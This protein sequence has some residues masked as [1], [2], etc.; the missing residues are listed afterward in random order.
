MPLTATVPTFPGMTPGGAFSVVGA[1]PLG[2]D[3]L[4]A[5]AR[6]SSP[7]ER[8]AVN[9]A[10]GELGRI[11]DP[12]GSTAIA[13]GSGIG[14]LIGHEWNRFTE[15]L[16]GL[17]PGGRERGRQQQLENLTKNRGDNWISIPGWDDLI[18]LA[19][20]GP[21][22]TSE[23]KQQLRDRFQQIENSAQPD[24]SQSF[25]QI[26]TALDN[27]QD[28]T[29]ALAVAG[30]M[31]L[32][33]IGKFVGG[34]LTPILGPI[35]LAGDILKL[36][37][38][39]GLIA[40]PLYGLICIGPR[41]LLSGAVPA[42]VFGRVGKNMAETAGALNPLGR[43]ARLARQLKLGRKLPGFSELIEIAQ[44]TDSLFGVGI[45]F[46]GLV[47]ALMEGAFGLNRPQDAGGVTVN[48]TPVV[49]SFNNLMQG[50]IGGLDVGSTWIGQTAGS[51]LRG[52][53]SIVGQQ[54]TFT[55][56]EHM[57]ALAA[58]I[59]AL[60]VARYFLH[61]T[62]WQEI[63]ADAVDETWAVPYVEETA[64]WQYLRDRPRGL[65]SLR[66]WPIPGQPERVNVGGWVELTYHMT[67]EA[68]HQL[69]GN[70]YETHEGMCYAA[71]M[72][73]FA[74]RA[75][76]LF[77]EDDEV[78]K[79]SLLPPYRLA[80]AMM[81]GNRYAHI[82]DDPNRVMA[83]ATAAEAEMHERGGRWLTGPELDKVAYEAGTA[84]IKTT[85]P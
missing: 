83:F 85:A 61:G 30:R 71:M 32:W 6:Q 66:R 18:H 77:E 58:G 73:T 45:S 47:G 33:P 42:A 8:A 20:R 52:L 9:R 1:V 38:L 26:L 29:T 72:N 57:Q 70:L 34:R 49:N 15:G 48:V 53:G 17:T 50:K 31:L 46:G 65:A 51:V 59:A 75:M 14:G 16:G 28:L 80:A 79:Y 56:E 10:L 24:W 43:N 39:L 41:A 2:D 64:S 60:D 67:R 74:E 78:V 54:E 21:A 76:L 81:T 25:G 62:G 68:T 55:T 13:V 27:V 11:N 37:S 44:T 19:P 84:L 63:A 35:L 36:L 22:V 4:F 23:Q 3:R 5:I 12:I 69:L 40:M 7:S 82:G